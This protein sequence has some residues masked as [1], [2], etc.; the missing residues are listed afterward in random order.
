MTS[1]SHGRRTSV[2][3][4]VARAGAGLSAVRSGAI[5]ADVGAVEWTPYG[6]SASAPLPQAPVCPGDSP[7]ATLAPLP[8]RFDSA[9]VAA[10]SAVAP[11]APGPPGPGPTATR[12]A[13]AR[14]RRLGVRSVRVVD[15]ALA[16][17]VAGDSSERSGRSN[18]ISRP[19]TNSTAAARTNAPGVVSSGSRIAGQG[20]PDPAAGACR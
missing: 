19:A 14:R 13:A 17:P 15:A 4:A 2:D 18:A 7:A 20:A 3:V 11:A 12:R 6:T 1:S 16:S 10:A 8:R 9:T 5:V